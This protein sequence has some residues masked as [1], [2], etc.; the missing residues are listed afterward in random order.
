MLQ[1]ATEKGKCNLLVK[2]DAPNGGSTLSS[3]NL[4]ITN[5]TC[6]SCKPLGAGGSNNYQQPWVI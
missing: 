4:A 2:W 3:Q 6:E 5:G 1:K